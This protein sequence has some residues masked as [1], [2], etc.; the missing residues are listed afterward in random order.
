[1]CFV[2]EHIAGGGHGH[3]CGEGERIW[4]KRGGKRWLDAGGRG[5]ARC[6][7]HTERGFV[8]SFH[9]TKQ[10]IP[11]KMKT[12]LRVCAK[13]RGWGEGRRGQKNRRGKSPTAD[14]TL[15]KTVVFR[16]PLLALLGFLLGSGQS[17]DP[18]PLL[19]EPAGLPRGGRAGVGTAGSTGDSPS[20]GRRAPP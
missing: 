15:R 3:V 12:A 2:D 7:P 14:T 10:R 20:P 6:C 8:L 1:M 5:A 4:G 19:P 13:E 11:R 17:R 16:C 18:R 9:A